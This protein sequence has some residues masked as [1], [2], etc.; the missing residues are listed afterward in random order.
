M[1]GA[2]LASNKISN[3]RRFSSKLTGS[4]GKCF[5]IKVGKYYINMVEHQLNYSQQI[6]CMM[7]EAIK[8]CSQ[9]SSSIVKL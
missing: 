2:G 3:T 9:F 7:L 5:S 8:P 1:I 4:V 6:T